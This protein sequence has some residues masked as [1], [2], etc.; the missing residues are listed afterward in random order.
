MIISTGE[1]AEATRI[2]TPMISTRFAWYALLV[3][4]F[5]TLTLKMGLGLSP[6]ECCRRLH[7][8]RP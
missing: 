4:D 6:L 1:L 2:Y 3:T 8:I 7:T 5:M